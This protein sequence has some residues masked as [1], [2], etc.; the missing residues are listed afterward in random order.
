M[1]KI[2]SST[3]WAQ[4]PAINEGIAPLF[5][6]C[7]DPSETPFIFGHLYIGPPKPQS[8]F[9]GFSVSRGWILDIPWFQGKLP[10]YRGGLPFQAQILRGAR[11]KTCVYIYI[12]NIYIS[13]GLPGCIQGLRWELWKKTRKVEKS[14]SRKVAAKLEKSKSPKSRKVAAKLEKSKSPKSR[15]V[16]AKVEKSEKSKS[17]SKIR[18]VE[19]SKNIK[20]P[21]I[22]KFQD[23][24]S[25]IKVCFVECS[26]FMISPHP[27]LNFHS[28]GVRAI[29]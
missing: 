27:S 4:K 2:Q 19:K 5:V 26:W 12:Y 1:V 16:A 18:K 25:K 20:K 13:V 29:L 6:G 15:K 7:L 28:E 14:K 22:F 11:K 24:S 17:G 23:T 21:Q 8:F 9:S 3:K 10:W